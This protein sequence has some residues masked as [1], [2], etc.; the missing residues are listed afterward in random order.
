[1]ARPEDDSRP[2]LAPGCRWAESDLD[3]RAILFPEGAISI[4]GTG[5]EILKNC[6]GRRT[7]LEIVEQL[8][9]VYTLSDPHK[10][11]KEAADF[12]E[13]LQQRRIV[14]F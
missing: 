14:D 10:I 6:D 8:Q 11:R 3:R 1:L 2:R 9:D 13:Q 7:F 4:Q 5:L 12:L